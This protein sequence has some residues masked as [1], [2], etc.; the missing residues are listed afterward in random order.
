MSCGKQEQ[1]R[2]S[3]W[4]RDYSDLVPTILCSKHRKRQPFFEETFIE[5]RPRTELARQMGSLEGEIKRIL[6]PSLCHFS[7]VTHS[8]YTC[9]GYTCHGNLPT[10]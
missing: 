7:S 3:L 5:Y 10:L 4:P 9:H 6:I 2:L 1:N 8:K